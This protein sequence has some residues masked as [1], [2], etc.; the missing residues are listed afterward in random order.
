MKSRIFLNIF[1]DSI[2]D[3]LVSYEYLTTKPN[4]SHSK[5]LSLVELL[6][7]T[8]K[9]SIQVE[10]NPSL[11]EF[12]IVKKC[13][14]W[15]NYLNPLKSGQ[16]KN[17]LEM[18]N[19]LKKYDDTSEQSSHLLE[20]VF[21]GHRKYFKTKPG[22]L[23]IQLGVYLANYQRL[24]LGKEAVASSLTLG[25]LEEHFSCYGL[26][27]SSS[28]DGRQ[29]LI[30]ILSMNGLLVSSPDAGENSKLNNPYRMNKL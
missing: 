17:L 6:K 22:N 30:D 26:S 25:A 7:I 2:S 21:I 1:L 3:K 12:N 15:P 13:T 4:D 29:L 16:G 10:S 24:K 23:I 9:E 28:P 11:L 20:P 14:Y 5:S 19:M 27:F 18:L 8:R